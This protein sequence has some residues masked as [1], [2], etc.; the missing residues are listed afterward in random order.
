MVQVR[1]VQQ[2]L[3]HRPVM[4]LDPHVTRISLLALT[5]GAMTVH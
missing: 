1:H 5:C 2:R 3:R 4:H